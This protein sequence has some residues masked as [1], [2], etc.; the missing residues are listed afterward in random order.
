MAQ[1]KYFQNQNQAMEIRKYQW[2]V[3]KRKNNKFHMPHLSI[4]L[5][6]NS[7]II[8]FSKLLFN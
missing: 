7:K 3:S 2:L 1:G 6:E 8:L 4:G 5:A